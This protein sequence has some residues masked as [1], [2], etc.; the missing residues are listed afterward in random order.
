MKTA[1]F[2]YPFDSS[3]PMAEAGR[4][5]LDQHKRNLKPSTI[6]VYNNALKALN[7]FLGDIAVGEI[8]I[9]HIRNYQEMRS[10]RAGANL[11]NYEL[12]VLQQ[13]LK[14]AGCWKFLQ[15]SYKPLRVQKRRAGH[16][17]TE[18]QERI[19]RE[20]A[21]SRTK[22]RLTAH[23]MTVMLSTTMGF[24]E[25]RRLR[26]R[27]VDMQQKTVTVREGAK[28]A[29]RERTIPLN[30]SAY[31]SMHWIIERWIA[32]GGTEGDQYILPHRPRREKGSW[33]FDEP[34]TSI[35]AT[36]AR[37]REEAGLPQLRVY[38]CRVQAITKLLSNP[39]VSPQ[40]SKEI[41]G[42][43][44]QAMQD[45]YSI[46]QFE[47]KKAALD[48]IDTRTPHES[49]MSAMPLVEPSTVGHLMHLEIRSEIARQLATILRKYG[50]PI[51]QATELV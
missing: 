6:R 26:R 32:L 48:A 43:I 10:A 2:S 24:G 19:L 31:E 4:R 46:Q 9:F 21:F 51:P 35:S 41:A 15:E 27:D 22:W 16:S 44:S 36:F 50:V 13:I 8:N 29:Y 5:W 28:T 14:H 30:K 12:F 39:A 38:D 37:I 18:E 23:C 1:H 45:R 42:H 7:Q 34:T 25:L 40:V 33:I 11:I 3:I 17:I 47:T 20:V 49:R